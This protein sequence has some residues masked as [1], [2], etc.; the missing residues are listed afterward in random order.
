MKLKSPGRISFLIAALVAAGGAW[1]A[2]T[3]PVASL[4]DNTYSLTVK[5]D[6]KFTRNTTKL[7]DEAVAAATE[8]CTKAGKQLQVVSVKEDKS[9]YL[10]GPYAQVTLTFKTLGP[11]DPELAAPAVAT[12][13]PAAPAS[14]TTDEL[15]ASLLKL[16]EL[17]KKG[18][19]TDE[20]FAAEKKKLLARSK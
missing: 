9:Q 13:M 19:L 12:A 17:H 18:I 4:G 5:A 1:A 11:D 10:V 20:E 3:S 7:K 14:L 2:S 15:Y 16:D 6:N 8:Y